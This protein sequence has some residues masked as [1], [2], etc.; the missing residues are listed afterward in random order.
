MTGNDDAVQAAFDALGPEPE[1]LVEATRILEAH[2]PEAVAPAP[3]TDRDSGGADTAAAP[4]T[5]PLGDPAVF[6]WAN[7]TPSQLRGALAHLT[8][9]VEWLD[10]VY[11]LPTRQVPACWIQH[12]DVVQELWALML[13]HAAAHKAD[14]PNGPIAFASNFEQAR[15]RLSAISAG[16]RCADGHKD[17]APA[18]RAQRARRS[19]YTAA[20]ESFQWAWPSAPEA[21]EETR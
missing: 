5:A 16:S 17:N 7:G 4:S 2:S 6:W 8:Y 3:D 21:S 10:A 18:D 20:D 14:Q 19:T 12:P 15:N 11:S 1:H 13:L 9:F